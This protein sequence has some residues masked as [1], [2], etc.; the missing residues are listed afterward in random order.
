MHKVLLHRFVIVY[1]EDIL[2]FSKSESEHD[3]HITQVVRQLREFLL[4]LKAEKCF[5][6]QSSVQFLGYI[7]NRKGVKM[8]EEKVSTLPPGRNPPQSRNSNAS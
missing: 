7:I 6:H 1:I 8:N 5:F 3:K 4:F 2:I